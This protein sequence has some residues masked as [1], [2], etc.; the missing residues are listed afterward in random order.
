MGLVIRTGGSVFF[1][2]VAALGIQIDCHYRQK[3][4]RDW[5]ISACHH[6]APCFLK[7]VPWEAATAV[8]L[9]HHSKALQ[10]LECIIRISLVE[11]FNR[12]GDISTAFLS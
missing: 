9:Y 12:Y 3:P 4:F 5:A 11:V 6:F 2:K 7:R 8:A 1:S 10:G